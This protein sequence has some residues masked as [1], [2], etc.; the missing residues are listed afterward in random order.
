MKII[1]ISQAAKGYKTI[2][3]KSLGHLQTMVRA[4]I[5][6][7]RKHDVV[8]NFAKS[9]MTLKLPQEHSDGGSKG[10]VRNTEQHLTNWRC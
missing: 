4:I 2:S 6:K 1:D 9:A 5:H 10:S 8:V 7:R 3:K